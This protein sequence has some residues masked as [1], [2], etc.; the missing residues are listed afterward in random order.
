M[1]KFLKHVRRSI[2]DDL[3]TVPQA[4]KITGIRRSTIWRMIR[5]GDLNA[6][7]PRRCYRISISELLAPVPARGCRDE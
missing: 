5:D 2:P 3:A 6:W 1:Q 7:G 4:S